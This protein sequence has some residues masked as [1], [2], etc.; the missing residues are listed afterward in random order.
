MNINCLNNGL[1][2]LKKR[3]IFLWVPM[4]SSCYMTDNKIT[5]L[6]TSIQC[7]DRKRKVLFKVCFKLGVSLL[8]QLV[9]C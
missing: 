4:S 6:E 1:L 2:D 3:V 8:F 7:K 5:S 9:M